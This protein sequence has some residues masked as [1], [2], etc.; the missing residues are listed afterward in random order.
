M[1]R[2]GKKKPDA[3]GSIT[4]YLSLCLLIL[5]SL[6]FTIIE[7]ARVNA[8]RVYGERA[9]STAMDSVLAEYY[10]PLWQEYHIFGY[11]SGGMSDTEQKIELAGK[12]SNY[13]SYTFDP[14]KEPNSSGFM[15]VTDLL[16][17]K[18]DAIEVN[19]VT[20]LMDYKAKLYINQAV[21]YSKYRAIGNGMEALL[22]KFSLLETPKKLSFVYDKK[23]K[24]EEE[25]VEI[26]TEILQLMKLLDGIKTGKKG[27]KTDHNGQLLIE[28]YFVKKICYVEP[29]KEATG[30]NHDVIFQRLCSE[31]INPNEYFEPMNNYITFLET[32]LVQIRALEAAIE[33]SLNELSRL[34]SELS[35]LQAEI[36]EEAAKAEADTD[37]PTDENEI[38]E[39]GRVKA[40]EE[41]ISSV[42]ATISAMSL[43]LSKLKEEQASTL[44]MLKTKADSIGSLIE[45]S[46]P[47]IR[48]AKKSVQQ[49]IKKAKEAQP[50]ISEYE[51][52][53]QEEKES[54]PSG[55]YDDLEQV[56]NK[57]K[58]YTSKIEGD[59]SY[60][61]MLDILDKNLAILQQAQAQC[62]SGRGWITDGSS[63]TVEH[64]RSVKS[65]Y[66]MASEYLKGYQ[67]KG[68]T[69]DYSTLV[70]EKEKGPDPL[71]KVNE[72]IASG[73]T[74][75]I[76][77]PA[78]ISDKKITAAL[79]PSEILELAEEDKSLMDTVTGFFK[80]ADYD[81]DYSGMG[82]LFGDFGSSADVLS[83]LG[84]SVNMISEH[85]L[86]QEY[87]KEHFEAYPVEEI[88]NSRK[89]S[90]LMYEQE[91]LLVGKKSD[92][93]NLNSVIQRILL[94]RLICNFISILGD[95]DKVN[96]AK[97]TA[98]AL[99]GFTGLPILVS[100]TQTIILMIWSFAEALLD[101]N[102]I[103]M[104]KAVPILKKQ[105]HLQLPEL[106]MLSRS[107]LQDKASRLAETKELSLTYM[108]YLSLFLIMSR[109]QDIAY[110]SLD[111]IQ[112]N[113]RIRYVKDD[114]D[115]A[116][117]IF[118]FRAKAYLH[119]KPKL[120]GIRFVQRYLSSKGDNYNYVIDATYSY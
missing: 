5:L 35:S 22:D 42:E 4:I 37:E 3:N 96:E 11:D 115:I 38:K 56:L 47:L 79:L 41:Q 49:I 90:I 91:Y 97:L 17:I 74:S 95:K 105:I 40:L 89:P 99:V 94:L 83:W 36:K 75:L 120:T 44:S 73:I 82:N 81:G 28:Q 65:H 57:L 93:E 66:S 46:I 16:D 15:K 60:Y 29:S 68:L 101:L 109:K 76:L 14:N 111:L 110:K 119:I 59:N 78:K 53:L 19:D 86:Y 51:A 20:R 108:D 107:F 1:T 21:E 43:E 54:L 26:D 88:A 13:M 114:F 69:L 24:A 84:N 45:H 18:I 67:I 30:I 58:G 27:L 117:C 63:L 92:E 85:L 98:A 102:G 106:F 55:L 8:A 104:G 31:Y 103:M 52:T 70:I 10:G 80:N 118:G 116:N 64:L 48:E 87:I 34:Q 6:I 12:L 62:S 113:L 100:I 32:N 9:L 77:D 7:G 61:N 112:E 50:L 25:L 23:L 72:L 71:S 2:V 33:S 39:D